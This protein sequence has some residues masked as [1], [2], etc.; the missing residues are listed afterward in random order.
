[1]LVNKLVGELSSFVVFIVIDDW[2]EGDEY[3]VEEEMINW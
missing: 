3:E 2:D 1:M